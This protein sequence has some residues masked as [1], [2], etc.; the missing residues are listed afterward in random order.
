MTKDLGK[1]SAVRNMIASIKE[2]CDTYR[3]C[4]N[5]TGMKNDTIED[6]DKYLQQLEEKLSELEK[7]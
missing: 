5:L 7:S 1:I 2:H 3:V 6:L 4:E